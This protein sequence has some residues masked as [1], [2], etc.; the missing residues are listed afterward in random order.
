MQPV[1]ILRDH[2]AQLARRFQLRQLIVRGVGLGFG[3][4]QFIPVK[5]EKFL[6]MLLIKRMT[7]HHLRRIVV[8]LMIQ[9]VGAA[10]ILDAAFGADAG[11]AEKHDTVAAVDHFLQGADIL[12]LIHK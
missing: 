9:P 8:L 4:E 6:R 1:D 12:L 7:Q 11:P 2:G 3:V 5:A 10:E